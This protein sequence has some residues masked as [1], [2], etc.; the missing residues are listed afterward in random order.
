M[1]CSYSISTAGLQTT[2]YDDSTGAHDSGIAW[3]NQGLD[4]TV[5][6]TSANTYSMT[7][8][9]LADNATQTKTGILKNPTGGQAI[10]QFRFWNYSQTGDGGS[11]YDAFLNS[12]II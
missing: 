9:R 12:M 3:T 1:T 2:P 4:V 10:S 7:I 8:I 5:T 11:A 6:L